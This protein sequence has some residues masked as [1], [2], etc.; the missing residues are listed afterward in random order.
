MPSLRT[1]D[2][3]CV[4][5]HVVGFSEKSGFLDAG[6]P[7]KLKGVGCESCHGPGSTHVKDPY[8]DDILK[9]LRSLRLPEVP[10]ESKAK[11][12]QDYDKAVK[13]Y[14]LA[15]LR[16]SDACR[17][18]HDDENDVHWEIDQTAKGLSHLPKW[19]KIVHSEEKKPKK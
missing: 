4:V 10:E 8:N 7:A 9:K 19:D 18:C 14:N 2:G 17:R 11:S 12:K 1:F 15:V 5:C 6:M 13:S 16:R 3:E